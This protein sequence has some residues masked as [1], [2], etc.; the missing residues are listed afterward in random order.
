MSVTYNFEPDGSSSIDNEKIRR[1]KEV[2]SVREVLSDTLAKLRRDQRNP[3]LWMKASKAFLALGRLDR[4]LDCCMACLKVDENRADATLL[5]IRVQEWLKAQT[6]DREASRH[7]E[8][9]LEDIV[10]RGMQSAHLPRAGDGVILSG[11]PFVW[12]PELGTSTLDSE[13]E[14]SERLQD[15]LSPSTMAICPACNTLVSVEKEWCHGCG[16]KMEEK[17]ETLERRADFA[18]A[19]L[20]EDEEDRDALFTLGAYLAIKGQHQEALEALNKLGLLEREYPGLWWL[21]A[22]VLQLMGN[23]EAASVVRKRAMQMDARLSEDQN[24]FD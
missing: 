20:Q 9:E 18:R 2:L 15:E 16:R 23:W 11:S 24:T 13:K 22:R 10:E 4:S 5:M 6:D 12:V 21:R 19:R 14:A 17:V 7:G 8:A 1:L 3:D